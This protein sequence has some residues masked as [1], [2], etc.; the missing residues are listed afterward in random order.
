MLP[1]CTPS[2]ASGDTVVFVLADVTGLREWVDYIPVQ[3]VALDSTLINKT[4][5]GGFR[6]VNSLG[7]SSGLTAFVD[8][9]P[10]F[11]VSGRTTPWSTDPD[12]YIPIYAA[13]GA[14]GG[15]DPDISAMTYDSFTE[16]NIDNIVGGIMISADG[17]RFY[18]AEDQAGPSNMWMNDNKFTA[19]YTPED[20]LAA[21]TTA[22]LILG[23]A[24]IRDCVW[25]ED[26]TSVLTAILAS[27]VISQYNHTD[28]AYEI[29]GIVNATPDASTPTMTAGK[30][31]PR[32]LDVSP[33]GTRI[34]Y[35]TNNAGRDVI[36][37]DLSTAWDLTTATDGDTFAPAFGDVGH[38]K[39]GPSGSKLYCVDLNGETLYEFALSTAYDISTASTTAD[40]SYDLSADFPAG[41][42]N[43][44]GFAFAPDGSK[45]FLMAWDTTEADAGIQMY[46]F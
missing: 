3:E 46:T 37:L 42:L 4:D 33:D 17:K 13:T 20:V 29:A 15:G 19:A 28:P 24:R 34:I 27:H 31:Q 10:V 43:V 25:G 16:F 7:S 45:L 6:Q 23:S 36:E 44:F 40:A 26:G 38:A 30:Q 41:V 21:D 22:V 2:D 32:A 14:V 12:G 39:F 8:Y 11:V 35:V 5:P 18:M 9:L 1:A